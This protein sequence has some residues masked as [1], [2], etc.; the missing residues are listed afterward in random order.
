MSKEYI[1]EN[2]WGDLM[3]KAFRLIK[4]YDHRFKRR[5][6]CRV[7]VSHDKT[8]FT[9]LEDDDCEPLALEDGV[10]VE[11]YYT[12]GQLRRVVL[13]RGRVTWYDE[14][15]VV[16]FEPLDTNAASYAT[17]HDFVK[18]DFEIRRVFYSALQEW[19]EE[20]GLVHTGYS[21]TLSNAKGFALS[22]DI[23]G[24]PGCVDALI[25]NTRLQA[26]EIIRER[27]R[28]ALE[29]VTR[30]HRP[31]VSHPNNLEIVK[32]LAKTL[33]RRRM[34]IENT[35]DVLRS[36]NVMDVMN[37]HEFIGL[38]SSS[39]S[40][41]SFFSSIPRSD[42]QG[43]RF[44]LFRVPGAEDIIFQRGEVYWYRVPVKR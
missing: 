31:S 12:H 14:A 6:S 4:K 37:N 22:F 10:S 32:F 21:F 36:L 43:A 30:E 20:T 39:Q 11:H 13:S 5:H 1:V 28:I 27:V 23:S 44:I 35:D 18:D 42:M 2:S 15:G 40:A 9:P 26:R 19:V 8:V 34:Y 24:S 25:F 38:T 41:R 29:N 7:D 17:Y 16:V 3:G 33:A